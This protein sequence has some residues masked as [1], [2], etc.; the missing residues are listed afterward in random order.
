MSARNG[1]PGDDDRRLPEGERRIGERLAG[2]TKYPTTD[3]QNARR[4]ADR[5]HAWAHGYL[6]TARSGRRSLCLLVTRC[7]FGCGCV[8]RFTAPQDFDRG[9]RSAPCGGRFI[10]HVVTAEGRVAA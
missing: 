1:P 7:P 9:L 6:V 5:P 2:L 4:R 3:R 8:H 10:L